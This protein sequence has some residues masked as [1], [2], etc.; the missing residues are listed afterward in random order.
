MVVTIVLLFTLAVAVFAL[1]VAHVQARRLE[2]A[3]GLN[4]R[5]A[6]LIGGKHSVFRAPGSDSVEDVR[7]D[8]N[9]IVLPPV[10]SRSSSVHGAPPDDLLVL[11]E[12]LR[13]H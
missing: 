3:V 6:A 1:V 5:L 8:P 4:R 7:T 13:D 9:G 10:D 12:S 2:V 11:A